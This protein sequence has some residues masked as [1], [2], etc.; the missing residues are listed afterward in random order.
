MSN[1]FERGYVPPQ[2]IER[3]TSYGV[4]VKAAH[5]TSA[6]A[7]LLPLAGAMCNVITLQSDV[8]DPNWSNTDNFFVIPSGQALARADYS[9]VFAR[10]SVAWG[11]GDGVNTF[12]LP[13]LTQT[14]RP[15]FLVSTAPTVYTSVGDYGSGSMSEHTHTIGNQL[16]GKDY[17]GSGGDQRGYYNMSQPTIVSGSQ[18]GDTNYHQPIGYAIR[19]F[20]M[21][22]DGGYTLPLGYMFAHLTTMADVPDILAANPK[23][24]CAS[25]QVISAGDYANYA[26]AYGTTLPDMQ[27]RFARQDIVGAPNAG[28]ISLS[29]NQTWY[30][31]NNAT[32]YGSHIHHFPGPS[33]PLYCASQWNQQPNQRNGNAGPSGAYR[34]GNPSSSY[35]LGPGNETRPYNFSVAYFIKVKP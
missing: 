18:N 21:T 30:A 13:D 1:R 11:A 25:G 32:Y 19:S 7:D 16:A 24:L 2:P 33:G 14:N 6:E 28:P 22:T 27:G 10:L 29:T 5:A 17:D 9:E 26:A 15:A 4:Q 23:I 20:L 8:K 3:R 35:S 31:W 34:G 12:N